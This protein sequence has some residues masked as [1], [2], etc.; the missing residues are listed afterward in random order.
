MLW[1][2]RSHHHN[3]D[4]LYFPPIRDV[5]FRKINFPG[6][7]ETVTL[8]IACFCSSFCQATKMAAEEKFWLM[9]LIKFLIRGSPATIKESVHRL[10]SDIDY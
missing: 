5:I 3:G 8:L 4:D 7:I 10:Q 6:G 9:M 1:L 2:L